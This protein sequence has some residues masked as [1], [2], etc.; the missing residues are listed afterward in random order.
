MVKQ[1][2]EGFFCYLFKS[3]TVQCPDYDD[4]APIKPRCLK[5]NVVLNWNVSGHVLKCDECLREA[6]DGRRNTVPNR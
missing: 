5:Y 3:F 6:F 4:S 2:P 1:K